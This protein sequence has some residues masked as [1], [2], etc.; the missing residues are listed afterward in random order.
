M[1]NLKADKFD[2]NLHIIYF[3]TFDEL[4]LS[5]NCLKFSHPIISFEGAF[6]SKIFFEKS[7]WAKKK[8]ISIKLTQCLSARTSS[9]KVTEETTV[10]T[11]L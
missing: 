5:G 11:N 3:H 6:D 2:I 8:Q 10:Y 1:Q 4:K 9:L 7:Q